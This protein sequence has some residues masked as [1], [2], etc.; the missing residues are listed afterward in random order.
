MVGL[1]GSD[2]SRNFRAVLR[3][4]N[5]RKRV[6]ALLVSAVIHVVLLFGALW[7]ATASSFSG[8]RGAE[9]GGGNAITVTLVVA[10]VINGETARSAPSTA[11]QAHLDA[12][13]HKVA[14]TSKDALPVDQ[15]RPKG[16][17][18]KLFG[19]IQSS[20][21]RAEP[22]APAKPP[23]VR[24]VEGHDQERGDLGHVSGDMWSELQ[25]C[26]KPEA[27]VP[28]TLEV[29]VDSGGRLAA[30]PRILRPEHAVLD[31]RRLHAEAKAIEAVAKCAP[32]TSGAPLIGRTTYRFAFNPGP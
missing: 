31:E 25:T 32:F 17:L 12:L 13:L 1:G 7:T 14:S 19:E 23:G 30:P 20:H 22:L 15:A 29:V 16:D 8:G 6:G 5:R 28:V 4:S 21:A 10:A 11:T 26:W 18:G 24:A 3:S 2:R 27:Q 9:P